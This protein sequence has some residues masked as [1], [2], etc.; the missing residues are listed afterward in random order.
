MI[1]ILPR[2]SQEVILTIIM[3]PQ[4]K[5]TIQVTKKTLKV[6][7]GIPEGN[8]MIYLTSCYSITFQSL[9]GTSEICRVL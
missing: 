1:S 5:V 7:I 6:K 9:Q 3:N 4:K 2:Y 8:L